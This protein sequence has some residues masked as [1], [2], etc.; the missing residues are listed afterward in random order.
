MILLT[1]FILFVLLMA[2][3]GY[4]AGLVRTIIRCLVF[5]CAFY[6][7]TAFAKP[8]AEWFGSYVNGQFFRPGVP[9]NLS[10]QGSDFLAAGIAFALIMAAATWLGHFLLRPFHIIHRLP[11]LGSLDAWLG[12]LLYLALGLT[13]SFFI[14]Q[15]LSVLPNYWLQTQ[16][17]DTDLLNRFLDEFPLFSQQIYQWWL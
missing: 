2:Y 17:S 12:A 14:L 9:E 8:L 3:S 1:I 7:A 6:L 15:L 11:I 4:Q 13:L 10:R 5:V 16:F